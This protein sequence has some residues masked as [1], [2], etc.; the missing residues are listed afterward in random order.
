MF[1]GKRIFF[2][3][4]GIRWIQAGFPGPLYEQKADEQ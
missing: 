1:C 3:P 4:R 2:V